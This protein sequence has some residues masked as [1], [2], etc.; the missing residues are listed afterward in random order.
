MMTGNLPVV[1]TRASLSASGRAA[2]PSTIHNGGSQHFFGTQSTSRPQSFQQQTA[3]LQQSMQ[4]SHFAPVAAGGRTTGPTATESRGTSAAGAGKPSAG[5]AASDREVNSS[6]TRSAGNQNTASENGNRGGSRTFTPS[7]NS[8]TRSESVQPERSPA[9]SVSRAES[10]S[11]AHGEPNRSEWKTFTPPSHS[12]ESAGRGGSGAETS[13]RSESGSYWNR[14]APSTGYSRGS[15]SSNYERGGSSRPQL[16]MRQPI[17]QPRS[18]GGY[19]GYHGV[20]SYGGGSRGAPSSGGGSHSS[21][22]GGS[23]SSGGGHS[24]GGHH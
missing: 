13:S 19:G 23:H 12:A 16:N 7:S 1:P 4:Q 8:N 2:A 10:T 15:G 21:G 18:S 14:T 5:T 22:G 20:P 24:G 3:H 9:P 6:V 11:P 17:V